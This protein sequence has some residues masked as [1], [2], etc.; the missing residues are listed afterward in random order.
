MHSEFFACS[1][2]GRKAKFILFLLPPPRKAKFIL[3]L[4]PPPF[5]PKISWSIYCTFREGVKSN[6]VSSTSLQ[7]VGPGPL[8]KPWFF[9]LESFGFPLA[10]CCFSL[11]KPCACLCTYTIS[12]CCVFAP[13]ANSLFSLCL[14]PCPP[15][16][17][18]YLLRP[19]RKGVSLHCKHFWVFGPRAQSEVRYCFFASTLRPPK[20]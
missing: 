7:G 12:P 2:P 3:L 4:L 1:G 14:H 9:L 6:G 19:L 11:G 20:I 17:W 8:G 18:E 5:A 13:S 10:N 15:D 16:C